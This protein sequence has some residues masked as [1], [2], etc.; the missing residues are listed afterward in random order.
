MLGWTGLTSLEEDCDKLCFL[1]VS[2]RVRRETT[3]LRSHG[4]PWELQVRIRVPV[5]GLCLGLTL[6]LLRWVEVA[7][8]SM[9]LRVDVTNSLPP[10]FR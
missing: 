5:K 7:D 6:G 10:F 8:V 1:T 9:I 2:Y 3:D 4:L